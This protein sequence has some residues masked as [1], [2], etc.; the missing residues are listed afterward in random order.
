MSATKAKHSIH[1]HV[2][3]VSDRYNTSNEWVI[4]SW[5]RNQTLASDRDIVIQKQAGMALRKECGT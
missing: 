1:Y 3:L 5:P 2:V 4:R